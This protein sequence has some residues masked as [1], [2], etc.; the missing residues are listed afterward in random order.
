[1][2]YELMK[3][4]N[5]AVGAVFEYCT[6]TELEAKIESFEPDDVNEISKEEYDEEIERK[7]RK[8]LRMATGYP[9]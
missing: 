1:M 5:N 7:H 8:F 2:Y 6:K 4:A 9:K 3:S